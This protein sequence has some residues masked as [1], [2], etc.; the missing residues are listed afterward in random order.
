M[1]DI[2]LV[3]ASKPFGFDD[4]VLRGILAT[5]RRN[6]ERDS[7]TGALVCREDLF[8]QLLEGPREKVRDTFERICRDDRHIDVSKLI[9]SEINGRLFPEWSMRHDPAQSW[10]WT[11]EQVAGGAVQNASPVEV[12]GVFSRLAAMTPAPDICGR[13]KPT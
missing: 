9:E 13:P 10:M 4:L 5:A 8:L 3:Y 11:R 1:T 12:L 2:Q 6:N 7:I